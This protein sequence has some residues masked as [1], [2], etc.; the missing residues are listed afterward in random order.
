MQYKTVVG[1]INVFTFEET[2][3]ATK[4]LKTIRLS[5]ETKNRLETAKGSQS[6]DDYLSYLLQF[7][8]ETTV[9]SEC[10]DNDI[11]AILDGEPTE[12]FQYT[13]VEYVKTILEK[14]GKTRF[15]TLELLSKA[16]ELTGLT[17][18]QVV[19]QAVETHAQKLVTGALCNGSNRGSVGSADNR[20]KDAI[21]NLFRDTLAGKI[22]TVT[23]TKITQYSLTNPRT[24]KSYLHR[25]S[26]T[27]LFKNPLSISKNVG[28]FNNWLTPDKYYT[29]VNSDVISDDVKTALEPLVITIE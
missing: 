17:I 15:S 3:S 29:I 13:K 28:N 14:L 2:M 21:N 19:R 12:F 5:E 22:E 10:G 26:L 11:N 18:A 25:V 20:I 4:N 16:S 23:A 9:N 24:V 7:S 8:R 27:G 6:Y 1:I